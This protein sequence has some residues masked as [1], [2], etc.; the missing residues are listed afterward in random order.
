MQDQMHLVISVKDFRAIVTH[1]HTLGGPITTHF[2]FPTRPLQFSYKNFGMHCEFTLMTTG[3]Y[4]GSST[5]NPKFISTR[6]GSRQP[7]ASRQPS[8]VPQPPPSRP[9]SEM[10]PPARPSFSKPLSSQSQRPSLKAQVRQ[11]LPEEND[12]DPESLFLPSGDEDATWDPPNYGA[13]DEEEE[14]L[15]WDAANERAKSGVQ[16][17]FRDS[18]TAASVAQQS[19]H[20]PQATQTS[21]LEPTQRLSEQ[22]GMFD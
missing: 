11:P 22:R 18:G 20:L 7:S 14:M 10:P 16:R 5:P 9:P 2:S 6:S 15:G 3:D 21:G 13:D 4:Q 19:E 12:P 17:T 8:I 1:A